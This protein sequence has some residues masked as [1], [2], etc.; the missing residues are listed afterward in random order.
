MAPFKP[1]PLPDPNNVEDFGITP[2][3][4]AYEM[5]LTEQNGKDDPYTFR[6]DFTAT[7][8]TQETVQL[9]TGRSKV[10]FHYDVTG[11]ISCPEFAIEDYF[12]LKRKYI[13]M[14][15]ATQDILKTKPQFTIESIP[16][17]YAP[18]SGGSVSPSEKSFKSAASQA[19]GNRLREDTAL[20]D[21]IKIAINSFFKVVDSEIVALAPKDIE[22]FKAVLG[23]E[24]ER[25]T[26]NR[27]HT[28]NILGFLFGDKLQFYNGD[29]LRLHDGMVLVPSYWVRA[30]EQDFND[31]DN[32]KYLGY[33]MKP[34]VVD[35]GFDPY[36]WAMIRINAIWNS[37]EKVIRAKVAFGQQR[38]ASV[39]GQQVYII[40]MRDAKI[41]FKALDKQY[42]ANGKLADDR[43][44][45]L[46]SLA[47]GQ[48]EADQQ[49][50]EK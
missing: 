22:E 7:L 43:M 27:E 5:R 12:L 28:S 47:L 16:W 42:F 13:L 50:Q 11:K 19:L 8:K 39:S 38:E 14:K 33:G 17:D 41:V 31:K 29:E 37:I 34:A 44:E 18:H 25:G 2:F 45:I 20:L 15:H 36:P 35:F 48:L 9:P 21:N 46:T 40:G 32:K 1:K 49:A 24:K 4:V 26:Y 30:T 10:V 6:A 3:G 23:L